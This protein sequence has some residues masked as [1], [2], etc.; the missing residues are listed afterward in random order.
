M[1]HSLVVV[2]P[3]INRVLQC[4]VTLAGA[5]KSQRSQYASLILSWPTTV[6]ADGCSAGRG[7]LGTDELSIPEGRDS[8]GI[9]LPWCCFLFP[10]NETDSS[11]TNER[12]NPENENGPPDL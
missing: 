7:V 3:D 2:S 1:L 6:S 8:Q 4:L 9:L 11:V 5:F 10:S 12:Q